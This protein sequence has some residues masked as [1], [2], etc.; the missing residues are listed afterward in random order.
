MRKKEDK[1]QR[2]KD[3]SIEEKDA[4][5]REKKVNKMA[6]FFGYTNEENPFGDS[7]LTGQFVWRKRLE[8]TG[9]EAATKNQAQKHR[10]KLV[11][12]I[13]KVRNR[14]TEREE[15]REEMERLK[16]EEQRL[17]EAEQY[18]DWQAREEEFHQ[19]QA[20]ERSKIRI[21]E[22]REKPIDVLAKNLLIFRGHGVESKAASG[23]SRKGASLPADCEMEMRE[24]YRV[25]EG[26]PLSE[27]LDLQKEIKTHADLEADGLDAEY[28][29]S[30]AIVCADEIKQARTRDEENSQAEHLRGS[31][32]SSVLAEVE[33]MFATK[34]VAVLEVME[35]EITSKVEGGEGDIEYWQSLLGYLV[36]YKA[37]AQLRESHTHML[38]G[39]LQQLEAQKSEMKTKR[40]ERGEQSKQAEAAPQGGAEQEDTSGFS[41]NLSPELA[42]DGDE[43]GSLSPM[44]LADGED[45][46]VVDADADM[47][48][49]Q[50]Q[51]Q[52]IMEAEQRKRQ[53]ADDDSNAALAM[54]KQESSKGLEDDEDVFAASE[55][56]AI[57]DQVYWWHDKYRPRKPRYFN[58][59]KTGY[60]WNKY[61]Q[62]HYDHD[63]PPPK[64]V[65]GYKFNV[66]YPDLIDKHRVSC[67]TLCSWIPQF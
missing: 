50:K 2:K 64:V 31:V 59:V 16:A 15:E 28:W 34:T 42:P 66:F 24:P 39:R 4:K 3:M 32:H 65:Q 37:K 19:K 12:E 60:E 21:N 6:S 45:A 49:L 43:D 53:A 52:A 30:L 20:Q 40:I 61:N 33:D 44:L 67:N 58:R 56:V 46:D 48:E 5:K 51:R 27:L 13:E 7:N 57:P 29:K 11:S 22:G 17:R 25:F 23:D 14:R 62:T 26:L 10:E 38:M 9:E 47:A 8:K 18:G 55:E 36:V 54:Y 35:N 63:N 1:K 41:P